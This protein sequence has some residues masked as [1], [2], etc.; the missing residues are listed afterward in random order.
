MTP[1][2]VILDHIKAT[3][4]NFKEMEEHLTPDEIKRARELIRDRDASALAESLLNS[5]E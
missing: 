4:G 5:G 3:G 2:H 1:D